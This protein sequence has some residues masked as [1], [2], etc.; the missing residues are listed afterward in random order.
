MRGSLWGDR[1]LK[2]SLKELATPTALADLL[3][4]LV[5]ADGLSDH[6]KSP[7]PSGTEGNVL[8]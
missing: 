6:E 7:S 4:N 8:K 5:L 2:K 1:E 3:K